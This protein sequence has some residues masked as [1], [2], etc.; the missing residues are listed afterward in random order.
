MANAEYSL[1]LAG[2][3][4]V[5][6]PLDLVWHLHVYARLGLVMR[7]LAVVVPAFV[8]WDLIVVGRWW[9]YNA[10]YVFSPRVGGLPLEEIAFFAVVPICA[11][12]TWEVVP[13]ALE[14]RRPH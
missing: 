14:S 8:A 7:A 12:L 3:L 10:R 4:A 11:I 6:L 13:A 5:T 9:D 2:C 1:I